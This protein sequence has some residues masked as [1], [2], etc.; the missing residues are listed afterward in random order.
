MVEFIKDES[1]SEKIKNILNDEVP[2]YFWINPSSSSG[3]YHPSDERGKFG[4]VLHTCRVVKI[5]DDL[6]VAAQITGSNRE[7][8][9]AAAI[10]H[11][12]FKYDLPPG[13]HHTV[14]LHCIIPGEQLSIS[15]RI[16]QSI[17][18]HDGQWG[19]P[20]EWQYADEYQQ[21]LHYADYIASRSYVHIRIP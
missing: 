21:L 18:T 11:D 1:L 19:I 2:D 17:R 5:V 4:L 9:I 20:D 14:K 7:E 16:N 8:L 15:D 6:C 13:N 12:S 10:L 3:K